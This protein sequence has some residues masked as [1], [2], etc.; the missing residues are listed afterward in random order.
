MKTIII[1]IG[2]GVF[3]VII[4]A[5]PLIEKT[6]PPH[7]VDPWHITNPVPTAKISFS[8]SHVSTTPSVYTGSWT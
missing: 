1:I 6:P 7:T 5:S 3:I 8:G 4:V 2:T